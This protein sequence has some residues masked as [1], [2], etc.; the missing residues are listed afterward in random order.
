MSNQT[1]LAPGDASAVTVYLVLNDFGPLGRVY[2][3]TDKTHA[4]D[5]II[6]ENILAVSIRNR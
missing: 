1:P 5:A 3:E 6:V 2:V 4:N